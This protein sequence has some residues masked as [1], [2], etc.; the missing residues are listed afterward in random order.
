MGLAGI[1]VY[2]LLRDEY[3]IQI[4]FGD[5]GNILAIIT[6]A[7]RALEIERLM[8][9]RNKAALREISR[10]AVRPRVHQPY[11][12]NAPAAGVLLRAKINSARPSCRQN[13]RGIC[14][15]LPAR[16]PHFSAR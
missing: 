4:E 2:D 3:G 5:I 16:N 11:R 7:D 12:R 15:V 13:L 9:F 1:E 6:G 14:Y 10:R 8:S